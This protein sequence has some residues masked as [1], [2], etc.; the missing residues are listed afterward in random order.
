MRWT[1]ESPMWALET[2]LLGPALSLGTPAWCLVSCRCWQ[3][4]N[5]LTTGRCLSDWKFVS[6]GPGQRAENSLHA[7]GVEVKL[8]GGNLATSGEACALP[9][10]DGCISSIL[11]KSSK[12]ETLF[13]RRMNRQSVAYYQDLLI[14]WKTTQQPI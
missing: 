13:V 7:H 4:F 8:L 2:G 9:P 5:E 11:G 1:V 12:L 14:Q 6:A 3:A 10:T